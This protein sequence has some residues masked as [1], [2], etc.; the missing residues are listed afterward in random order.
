MIELTVFELAKITE[1]LFHATAIRSRKRR[2]NA[3]EFRQ[4]QLILL[5]DLTK[6]GI[7][8]ALFD[9]MLS[10]ELDRNLKKQFGVAFFAATIAFTLLAYSIIILNSVLNWEIPQYAVTGLIIETPI[11]FIGL[12]YII[13]RNLFPQNNQRDLKGAKDSKAAANRRSQATR[14]PQAKGTS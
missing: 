12:L 3:L 7:D 13:A 4:Q 8:P 5:Q 14:R 10:T 2:E 11:Q 9:L 1:R 6:A